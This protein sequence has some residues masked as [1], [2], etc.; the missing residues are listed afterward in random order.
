MGLHT[1]RLVFSSN[2][3]RI[4]RKLTAKGVAGL[5]VNEHQGSSPFSALVTLFAK[6][7]KRTTSVPLRS[8]YTKAIKYLNDEGRFKS[9]REIRT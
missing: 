6:E 4:N 2:A 1:F 3:R 5:T 9:Q 8:H 7:T